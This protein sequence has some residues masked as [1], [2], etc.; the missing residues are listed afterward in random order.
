MKKL[1]LLISGLA[2]GA[3]LATAATPAQVEQAKALASSRN[4]IT[5]MP[6]STPAEKA[7]RKAAVAQW[8]AA[9]AESVAALIPLVDELPAASGSFLIKYTLTAR[10]TVD[11]VI[12]SPFKRDPADLALAAKL[13][14]PG[15]DRVF[16]YKHYATAEEI[17]ALPGGNSAGMADAVSQRTLHLD[18]PDLL[19]GYFTRCLAEGLYQRHYN[20]WFDNKVANLVITKKDAEAA[21]LCKEEAFVLNQK[22]PVKTPALT[23]RLKTLRGGQQLAE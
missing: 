21:R 20:N 22:H 9:N 2:L 1:M 10:N 16:Y 5:K 6:I 3:S 18:A 17:A 14:A 8:D 11:G 12:V 23:E 15:L 7:A 13:N 4:A 19:D